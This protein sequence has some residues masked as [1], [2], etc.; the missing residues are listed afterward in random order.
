MNQHEAPERE[1]VTPEE[2]RAAQLLAQAL[3]GQRV[4]GV[5]AEAL[6]AARLLQALGAGGDELAGRRL[7][8]SLVAQAA[9]VRR[10]IVVKRLALAAASFAVVALAGSVLWLSNAGSRQD[11]LAE[12]ELQAG[13]AVAAVAGGWDLDTV[14]A[15][16][17]HTAFDEQWRTRLQAEFENERAS[18]LVQANDSAQR[19]SGNTVQTPPGGMS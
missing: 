8:A 12:R 14:T 7:R 5:D 3:T 15:A 6:R 18:A 19:G 4:S 16:R 9:T 2:T 10:S 13:R 11:L 17:V 1:P